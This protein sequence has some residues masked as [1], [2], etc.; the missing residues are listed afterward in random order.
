VHGETH[1][2]TKEPAIT[3]NSLLDISGFNTVS[4]H[5]GFILS[6]LVRA[7]PLNNW[8]VL[9]V[10]WRVE[11]IHVQRAV[12]RYK[13]IIAPELLVGGFEVGLNFLSEHLDLLERSEH[14][15][16]LLVHFFV[17][18]H[19]MTEFVMGN[20]GM[21]ILINLLS[22]N[23]HTVFV[24]LFLSVILLLTI[25]VLVLLLSILLLHLLLVVHDLLHLLLVVVLFV[26]LLLGFFFLV[27]F[28]V[29][30]LLLLSFLLLNWFGLHAFLLLFGFS[31]SWFLSFGF[32][33]G[34]LGLLGLLNGCGFDLWLLHFLLFF[35]SFRSFSWS[36]V[37]L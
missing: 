36:F 2:G 15:H 1:E 31:F 29:F 9:S 5:F 33:L 34:S 19:F 17:S 35:L 12:I 22:L 18:S 10:I 30:L 25:V 24:I 27:L 11:G 32:L 13:V 23:L 7:F 8:L 4:N 26:D 28:D 6:H 14:L 20:L 3:K 21:I 16:L 37:F